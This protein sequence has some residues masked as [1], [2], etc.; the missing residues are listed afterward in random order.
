ML[1]QFRFE[2]FKSFRDD[3]ILDFS[4]TEEENHADHVIIVGKEKLLPAAAIFGANASGKTNVI[5]AF[6]F[7]VKYVINSFAYGGDGERKETDQP[8]YTP[9]LMDS[10]SREAESSF[11]VF[12]TGNGED[13]GT[14]YNYGFTLNRGGIVEEWLN[15]KET[16]NRKVLLRQ[17]DSLEL[18]GIPAK[19]K[20]NVRLSLEKET[21]AVSLGAKLRIEIFKT[22]RDWFYNWVFAD[23]GD[24]KESLALATM[25]PAGFSKDSEVRKRVVT[26]LS[27]F[28]PSIIDFQV[29]V[30]S[31]DDN[32]SQIK[33][34]AV[35]R[36]ND[37]GTV[38]IPLN[39]ES[40]GTLK[41]FALYP[42]LETVMK[43][44]GVFFVDEL[45]SR[46]HPLL[47]RSFLLTFLNPEINVNH[48]QIVFT[49][50]DAW[51]LSNRLLRRDEIWFTEKGGDGASTLYSL[52]DFEEKPENFG[53][54]T[55]EENYLL[56]KYGAIPTMKYL[57]VLGGE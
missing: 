48:A 27:S 16:R 35:H 55:Y 24:P 23:F 29:E 46:L 2:N 28:D 19:Q 18:T 22:V 21:L 34:D 5:E 9:F 57:D 12:F 38:N 49:T 6:L 33:I 52:A 1:I 17:K 44:G 10:V 41:M 39:Q 15:V 53:K 13:D 45:N 30:L 32:M 43:T 56:G 7:M 3:T 42:G 14:T 20:E 4:A 37:G 26:Y 8:V 31:E 47:A 50:H 51:Q 36:K 11:E 54:E 40:S 25:V